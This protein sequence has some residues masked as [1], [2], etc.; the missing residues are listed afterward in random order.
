MHALAGVPGGSSTPAPSGGD[1]WSRFWQP[2]SG[3]NVSGYSADSEHGGESERKQKSK[4]NS[5]RS[6]AEE[7]QDSDER[8]ASMIVYVTKKISAA[9]TS[10][11]GKP[12]LPPGTSSGA[13]V[14]SVSGSDV[15]M[16]AES[17][18]G[19]EAAYC[20]A[21]R[22]LQ[23]DCEPIPGH[24]F[25][26]SAEADQKSTHI[27]PA[28]VK[29][30]AK[31]FASLGNLLPLSMAS[32]IFARM[33]ER[34]AT[35]WRVAITGPQGTPYEGGFFVFDL[36]FP[37]QYPACAPKVK[38]MTTGGGKVAFNPNL[39]SCGKVCLSLLGTWR[40][41]GKSENWDAS[42]STV[43]QVLVSIQSL[44]FVA[45]PHFNE[46][47]FEAE[48]GTPTGEAKSKLYNA[49][50]RLSNMRYAMLEQLRHPVAPYKEVIRLH[51]AASK[52]SLYKTCNSWSEEA[53][54]KDAP[55]SLNRSA[56]GLFA[57][58][59]RVVSGDEMTKTEAAL[60]QELSKLDL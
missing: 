51:F 28:L 12:Q 47:G 50:V 40:G 1:S 46:P 6:Q 31:E 20:A 15:E 17:S 18:C 16:E 32:S 10:S 19:P 44:I 3:A 45:Q 13:A 55:D 60:C 49:H 33:D 42:V 22:E 11:D 41:S 37:A 21:L 54:G 5:R 36:Y 58:G 27:T 4:R 57:A 9:V 23:C 43:L 35:L 30:V 53:R 8:L 24:A 25:Q 38:F 26:S 14:A 52:N 48:M 59:C 39:Y 2:G 29:R 56:L 34:Y 7:E